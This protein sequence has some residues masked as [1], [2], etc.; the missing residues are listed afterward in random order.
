MLSSFFLPLH[1]KCAVVSWI[2]LND[3]F[4]MSPTIAAATVLTLKS[5]GKVGQRSLVLIVSFIETV[6]YCRLKTGRQQIKK[7]LSCG[8]WNWR[9]HYYSLTIFSIKWTPNL[10][11]TIPSAKLI[12]HNDFPVQVVIFLSGDSY[13]RFCWAPGKGENKNLVF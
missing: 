8:L 7:W 3:P 5:C 10:S 4:S 2:N 1:N 6:N 9:G 13:I 12:Y 11:Q